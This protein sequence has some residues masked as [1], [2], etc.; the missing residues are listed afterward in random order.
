MTKNDIIEIIN[1]EGLFQYNIFNDHTQNANEVVIKQENDQYSVYETDEKNK[2]KGEVL[3]FS[4]EKEA[5]DDF[6]K[7]L[8]ELKKLYISTY[9]GKNYDTYY[10]EKFDNKPN[11][12]IYASLCWP[13]IIFGPFWLIYRKMYK[14]ALLFIF[15]PI[16]ITICITLLTKSGEM[17]GEII[18]RLGNIILAIIGNSLYHMKIYRVINNIDNDYMYREDPIYYLKKYGGTNIV[19]AIILVVI[20]LTIALLPIIL[21]I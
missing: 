2:I 3:T 18:G 8:R 10:K 14:E 11:N 4:N 20:N 7:K 6:I 15:I 19:L 1:K 21:K 17:F 13:P 9:V 12:K 16:I 5:V